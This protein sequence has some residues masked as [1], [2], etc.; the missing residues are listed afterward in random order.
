MTPA[1]SIRSGHLVIIGNAMTRG[2]PVRGSGAGK[3]HSLYVWSQWLH[4][5]CVARSLGTGG[6]RYHSKTTT[7][8]M[9]ARML[10]R[11]GTSGSARDRRRTGQL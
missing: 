1:S 4:D 3:K 11:A 6:R 10:K 2:N 5:F 9:A 8:G 7:A